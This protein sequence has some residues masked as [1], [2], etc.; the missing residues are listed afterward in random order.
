MC[1]KL[2][3][4][5]HF[6]HVLTIGYSVSSQELTI[7]LICGKLMADATVK[8]NPPLAQMGMAGVAVSRGVKFLWTEETKL[9]TVLIGPELDATEQ[10]ML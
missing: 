5:V 4:A 6:C 2:S 8:Q 10:D 3:L 9:V 1:Q 7:G